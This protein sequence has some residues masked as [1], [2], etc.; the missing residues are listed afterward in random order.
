MV[1]TLQRDTVPPHTVNVTWFLGQKN[2]VL[3]LSKEILLT[4]H[5]KVISFVGGRPVPFTSI[6]FAEQLRS[7][8]PH[9]KTT[10]TDN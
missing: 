10:H 2:K 5:H 4:I 1:I 8:P 6:L 3:R 7:L 9:L